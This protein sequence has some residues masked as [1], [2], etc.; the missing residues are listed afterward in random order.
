MLRV[1]KDKSA[2]K[3]LHKLIKNLEWENSNL[4]KRVQAL[5]EKNIR[6][7]LRKMVSPSR[8]IEVK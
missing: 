7:E 8:A 2:I 5:E 6:A 4:R 3:E 1:N